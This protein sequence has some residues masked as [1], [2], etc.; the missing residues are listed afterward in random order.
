MAA[1]GDDLHRIASVDVA[2]LFGTSGDAIVLEIATP[3][4]D[5]D[6]FLFW[7][8][9]AEAYAFIRKLTDVLFDATVEE[10]DIVTSTQGGE[11]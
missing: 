7:L 11:A 10:A 2:R 6:T 4:D 5:D 9:D 8:Y 3:H 1:H